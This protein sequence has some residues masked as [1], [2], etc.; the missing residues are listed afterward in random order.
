MPAGCCDSM[1]APFM[2]HGIHID[3]YDV[4]FDGQLKFHTDYTDCTDI[5][6]V[7]NYFGYGNTL[8]IDSVKRYKEQGCIII[9]DRTHSLFMDND[10]CI[11]LASGW[12]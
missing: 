9:Y 3:F 7:I 11:T 1:L 5:L 4:R 2:A 8:P 10:P 6:Y 12:E